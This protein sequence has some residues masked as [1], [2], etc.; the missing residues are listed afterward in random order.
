MWYD[1]ATT[2]NAQNVLI[3][4]L[5]LEGEWETRWVQ[6]HVER[7][8]SSHPNAEWTGSEQ[9]NV[10]ADTLATEARSAGPDIG[11]MHTEADGIQGGRWVHH[12]KDGPVEE[13]DGI[14]A[15]IREGDRQRAKDKYWRKRQ[16][17]REEA[18]LTEQPAWDGRLFEQ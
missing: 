17:Q 1:R 15:L 5:D 14:S 3:N 4:D 12:T 16:T 2:I 18:E 11:I 10:T 9:V 7:R 6:G 8:S 13:C